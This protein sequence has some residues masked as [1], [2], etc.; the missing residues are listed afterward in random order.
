MNKPYM[1]LKTTMKNNWQEANESQSYNLNDIS[2]RHSEEYDYNTEMICKA[3]QRQ[4]AP[5]VDIGKRDGN[6]VNYQYFMSIFK[7]V[8]EDR[9]KNKTGRLI[10]L[11]KYAE[12]EERE[13]IKPCVQ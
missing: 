1:K 13:L 6:P 11:T 8:A 10:R 3:L 7:E 4:A 12:G 9:I 5:H 2:G